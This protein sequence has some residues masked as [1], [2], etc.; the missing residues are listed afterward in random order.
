MEFKDRPNIKNIIIPVNKQNTSFNSNLI[1]LTEC[2]HI[3]NHS[4]T[5]KSV[6]TA[7]DKLLLYNQARILFNKIPIKI[8]ISNC[9][10]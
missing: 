2:Q 7:I 3:K 4:I 5:D 10:K 6:A 9:L 8:T 1:S